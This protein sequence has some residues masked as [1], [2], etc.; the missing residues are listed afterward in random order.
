MGIAIAMVLVMVLIN[1]SAKAYDFGYRIFSEEPIAPA[2]GYTTTVAIVEGKSAKDI[3]EILEEKGLIR[4]ATLFYFQELL[5]DYHD[6]LQPGV[7]KLSTSMTPEEMMVIM[8]E[9]NVVEEN[10]EDEISADSQGNSM[11]SD[12]YLGTEEEGNATGTEEAGNAEENSE[13]GE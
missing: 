1:L 6:K 5:S 3:G 8:A 13:G 10:P 4:S 12:E 11:D 9:G 2:P 7:Y